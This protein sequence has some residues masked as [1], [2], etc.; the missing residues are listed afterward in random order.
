MLRTMFGEPER[1][2]EGR[3]KEVH[4]LLEEMSRQL[5]RAR[6]D[7]DSMRSLRLLAWTRSLAS[8]LD[9]LEQSVY[10]AGRYAALVTHE[11]VEEM[12]PA[13]EADYRRHLYFYKNG[14]IRVFSV[15]DKLGSFMNERFEL[16][17]ERMKARF[18][19]FTVL[20]RLREIRQRPELV[21]AL[22]EI[23]SKYR[24]PLQDL[25]LMRNH[26]VHAMNTELLDEDGR[27]RLRPHDRRERI[28][29]LAD[30]MR[31]LQSGYEAVCE[32][33]HAVFAYCRSGK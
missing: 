15:L 18:S 20:R 6:G 13:E 2:D 23:K 1:K 31:T 33:M 10:S 3:L 14:F 8:A 9:E 32:S 22:M 21:Q 29:D 24:D 17:T 25:R 16:H 28:E 30:N 5:E 4:A 27:L 7:G 26:E 19:Y 12:G 11:F